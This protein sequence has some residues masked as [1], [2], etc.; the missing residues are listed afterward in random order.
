MKLFDW[1][2]GRSCSTKLC[3]VVEVT[4]KLLTGIDCGIVLFV[5]SLGFLS[6]S[7]LT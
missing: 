7:L 5:F 3:L 2:D 6:I 1:H 4:G